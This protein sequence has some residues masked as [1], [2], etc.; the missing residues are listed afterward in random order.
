EARWNEGDEEAGAQADEAVDAREPEERFPIHPFRTCL[1]APDRFS[2]V[3]QEEVEGDRHD[4]S[5]AVGD[6]ERSDVNRLAA[7]SGLRL[8]ERQ[9]QGQ[10]E[11]DDGQEGVQ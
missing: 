11:Y 4:E 5:E 8:N 1:A 2:V 10:R 9:R 7:E 6:D 3:P